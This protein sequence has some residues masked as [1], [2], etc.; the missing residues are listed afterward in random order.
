MNNLTSTLND[1][2]LD[3]VSGGWGAAMSSNG[4][5]DVIRSL[6]EMNAAKSAID[7]VQQRGLM[8]SVSVH[9]GR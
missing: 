8:N 4:E 2:E 9:W 6:M 5:L 1:A 7:K 3:Y